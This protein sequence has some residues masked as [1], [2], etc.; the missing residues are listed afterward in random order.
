MGNMY[1]LVIKM[2]RLVL[3]LHF[4]NFQA[5]EMSIL[6]LDDG[7]F[8]PGYGIIKLPYDAIHGAI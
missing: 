5:Y 7:I 8:L 2:R 1:E 3:W 6:T 4:E